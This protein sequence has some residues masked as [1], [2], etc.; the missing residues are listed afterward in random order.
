MPSLANQPSPPGTAASDGRRLRAM[1]AAVRLSFTWFGV[2]RSLTAEQKSQAADP[3]GAAGSFLSAGK[4]LLDTGHPAFKAVSSVRS[5]I[6]SFW[7]GL[8]LPYP[9]AGIRLI[10]QDDVEMFDKRLAHFRQE[11][12][13]SVSHLDEHFDELKATARRQLGQLYNSA[14]YPASLVGLFDVSW[15][16]PSIEPPDYLRQLSPELYEQEARRA[17]AR[18]EEALQLAEQAFLEQLTGL[19][20]HLTERLAGHEDGKPK[21]FRDSAVENLGEFF[22]RFRHLNVRSSQQL[23]DLVSQAQ[24]IVQGVQPQAL[25]ENSALRQQVA[26]QLSGVQSVLDGLLVDRPRRTILR[27]PK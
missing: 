23:D 9:D 5:Q 19:V 6:V 12:A 15:D 14:D 20:S 11:L 17:A 13:E 26:T 1:M 24:R 10:R 16:F 4:K 21:I 3:F 25:R 7:R 27:R 18:F 22:E 8:T 2:R